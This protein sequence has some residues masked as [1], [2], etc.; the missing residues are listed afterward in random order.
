MTKQEYMSKYGFTLR[1]VTQQ[2]RA[3][4]QTDYQRRADY[5]IGY[6]GTEWY[7][8]GGSIR[9]MFAMQNYYS[10]S[11]ADFTANAPRK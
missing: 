5:M 1:R 7:S 3:E 8:M 11:P 2:D 6:K 9:D 4:A 10:Q